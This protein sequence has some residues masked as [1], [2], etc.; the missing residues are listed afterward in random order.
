MCP[1]TVFSS[2]L[3]SQC[4]I[5]G[6][7]FLFASLTI[8]AGGM[9]IIQLSGVSHYSHRCLVEVPSRESRTSVVHLDCTFAY[10]PRTRR[11]V[12]STAYDISSQHN[13]ASREQGESRLFI[14]DDMIE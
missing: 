6:V 13:T 8:R 5:E 12:R 4:C 10:R 7:L 9:M 2:Y 1:R 14:M 3:G 11:G